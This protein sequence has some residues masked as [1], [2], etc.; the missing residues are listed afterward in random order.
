M[1]NLVIFAMIMLLLGSGYM[2]GTKMATNM[3]INKM[4]VLEDNG[5]NDL[6]SHESR[7][8]TS[9]IFGDQSNSINDLFNKFKELKDLIYNNFYKWF[10]KTAPDLT[11]NTDNLEKVI[12]KEEA[13]RIAQKYI[14]EPGAVAGEPV[15]VTMDK[16]LTYIVPV[17]LNGEKVGEI[18]IDARTGKNLGGAGGVKDN[19][20]E[21]LENNQSMV[22]I[23]SK[24]QHN[25]S[26]QENQVINN[27]CVNENSNKDPDN[28]SKYED[29]ILL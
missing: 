24:E 27:E 23:S 10:D 29:N 14:E 8:G 22:D 17:L 9:C 5:Y 2:Y 12:S 1:K 25:E 21:N 20:T 26:N 16:K 3:G 13:K 15:L 19:E 4:P 6:K 7:K 18:Y 11:N 28:D